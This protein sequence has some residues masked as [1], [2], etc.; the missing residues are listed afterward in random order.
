LEKALLGKH[1][2]NFSIASPNQIG[3]KIACQGV[4]ADSPKEEA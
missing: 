3:I 1:S 4:L 2:A